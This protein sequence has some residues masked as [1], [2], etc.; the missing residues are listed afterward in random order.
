MLFIL[1]IEAIEEFKIQSAVYLAEYGMNSGRTIEPGAE[2]R[3]EPM[4]WFGVRIPAQ[5]QAGN[6]R[7]LSTASARKNLLRRNQF[8]GT[9]SG[10]L[11]KDKTFW[12]VNYEG[13]RESLGTPALQAVPTAAMRVGDF[14]EI[15]QPSNRWYPAD[16]NPAATRSSRLPGDTAPF[17]GNIIPR[18]LIN[19][20]SNNLPH[21]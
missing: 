4:A 1:S 19:P 2:V 8:G 13:K 18:S 10:P 5:R 3:N 9:L 21:L 16:A 11:V 6:P 14:A 12:L 7:L 20:V 15:I 17:P